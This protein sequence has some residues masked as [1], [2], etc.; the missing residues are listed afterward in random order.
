MTDDVKV[1]LFDVDGVIVDP[2]AYRSGVS[3]TLE[4]LCQRSGIANWKDL[5]PNEGELAHMESLGIHDVWD[6][7]D[8]VFGSILD[9]IANQL[10]EAGKLFEFNAAFVGL[11][12]GA[13]LDL[14]ADLSLHVARPDYLK[15]GD[16]IMAVRDP[17]GEAHPP[18]SARVLFAEKL[19]AYV[20][21]HH[22]G[23]SPGQPGM[24]EWL[25]LCDSFLIDTRTPQGS[26]GT[27]LFQNIILGEETFEKTTGLK[28]L[29]S[30]P[31]LLQSDRAL[32]EMSN[33]K[34]LRWLGKQPDWHVCVYTARP[35]YPLTEPLAGY[36]P[37]AEAA[38]QLAGM[39]DFT[40]VGMGAMDWL[41]AENG[42]RSEDLTKPN[43]TQAVAALTAALR[44]SSDRDVLQSAYVVTRRHTAWDEIKELRAVKNRKVTIYIFEDT[45][46]GIRPIVKVAEQLNNAGYAMSVQSRGIATNDQKRQ[47]LAEFCGANVFEDV[48]EALDS[49]LQRYA[50]QKTVSG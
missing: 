9:S 16:S 29:Y 33:V 38:L 25:K 28:S 27:R 12:V 3:K 45:V 31:S 20:L 44:K 14:I 37:E 36:S 49:V 34:V 22:S 32:I 40:L 4:I 50:I 1:L 39:R 48:N 8:I 30:G 10:S 35:S 11:D 26:F 47:A 43:T 23:S 24:E 21:G 19:Q 41:A 15:L 7:T 18:D 17:V 2:V 6:I 46:S 13:R 5:L 42:E